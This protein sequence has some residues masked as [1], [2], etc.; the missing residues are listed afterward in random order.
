M[1]KNNDGYVLP[2]VLVVL[3]VMSLVATAALSAALRN[4]KA[5]QTFVE[6]MEDR[7]QAEGAIER[8][9]AE[10]TDPS[11]YT[12]SVSGTEAEKEA[13]QK[14]INEACGEITHDNNNDNIDVVNSPDPL[15]PPNPFTCVFT[16]V[17]TVSENGNNVTVTAKMEWTGTIQKKSGSYTIT[18]TGMKYLSYEIG[19][20]S[21]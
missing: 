3:I 14:K 2:F 17:S 13:I 18:P 7:Y 6:R 11:G 20:A 19:G 5:Q 4:L 21:E 15:N 10:L 16:L 8:V 12:V 1:K 9:V